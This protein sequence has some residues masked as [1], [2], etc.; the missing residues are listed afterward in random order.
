MY[1]FRQ[2]ARTITR[3][4]FFAQSLG[5]AGFITAATVNAIVGA[6]LSG[7]PAWAGVPTSVY[8]I[9]SALAAGGW[10]YAMERIGRR[11]GLVIG[12]VC[13]M[14]GAG[15]AGG[16]VIGRSF[17]G[18]LGGLVLMGV[19]HAVLQLARFAA[20]EVHSA[21]ERG[22]AISNVVIGGTIGSVL[23]PLVVG[24]VG[25]LARTF[26]LDELAGPYFL[27][28]VMFALAGIV[29]F[30]WLRPDPRDVGRAL[31]L[32]ESDS[33]TP[34]AASR[35][36]GAI[37][38]TPG[39]I[40]AMAAMI[41]GQVTMV[42][43]MV[44]TALHMKDHQHPLQSISLVISSHTFGMFAFSIISGRLADR[45]GRVPV[46]MIGAVT[47]IAACLI[48]PLSLRALPIG[49]ALF[50]L[51]LGWNFC[52]VG[53][54]SLLADQLAPAERSR[55]QGVNDLLIGLVSAV[56]SLS[57]GLIFATL[58]YATMGL[59]GA[60]A[61]VI[62]LLLVGWWRMTRRVPRVTPDVERVA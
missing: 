6:Q 39:T 49:F 42:M 21:A 2:V 18:L 11:N 57:S 30:V 16:A 29:V 17:G 12:M 56:G 41:F 38:K 60:T 27:S 31:V 43:L 61:A 52:F 1:D 58:G 24:P 25:S 55:I 47:L 28:L 33:S 50:L 46:I 14:V 59:I 15:V 5:S 51:G 48:A 26:G 23:G 54:S 13:G 40:V 7:R 4:L 35:S 44:I 32:H 53:G 10:G 19:A 22:R 9:G 36:I 34:I 62:P 37:M 45:L 3:T 8:L 20:A